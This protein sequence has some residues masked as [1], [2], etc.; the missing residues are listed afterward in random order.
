MNMKGPDFLKK[1]FNLHAAPEV[2][3]A[4]KRTAARTGEKVPQKAVEQ[5]QNYLD[6]F[7]EL[8]E[9]KDDDKKKLGMRALK[10]V[11]HDA[12]VIKPENIP[13]SHFRLLQQIQREQ[14]H[15]TVEVTAEMRKDAERIIKADQRASLDRWVDYLASEQARYPD[16]CKYWAFRSVVAMSLYDKEKKQF[17]NRSKHTTAPFPDLNREALAYVVDVVGKR[18]SGES[19]ENPV[20]PTDDYYDSGKLVSDEEFQHILSTE[21][22]AKYYAFA[23]EHVIADSTELLKTIEGQWRFFKQGSDPLELAKTLQGHGTGWCVA[24]ESTAEDYLSDGD[25]HVYYS[26]NPHNVPTIPRLSI[27]MREGDID[28]VRGVAHEQEIDPYIGPVLDEKLDEFGSKAD[29]WKEKAADMKWLTIIERKVNESEALTKDD[30]RFLY[31]I[32]KNIEGFGNDRDPRIGEIIEKRDKFADARV[33]LGEKDDN[34]FML[35]ILDADHSQVCKFLGIHI[36]EGEELDYDETGFDQKFEDF[37]ESHISEMKGLSQVV[38]D[39]LLELYMPRL[40]ADARDSFE[41]KDKFAIVSMMMEY[42]KEHGTENLEDLLPGFFNNV[43]P[44]EQVEFV[45]AQ[46]GK[47]DPDLLADLIWQVDHLP[48]GMAKRLIDAGEEKVL[49]N[50][51]KNFEVGLDSDVAIRLIEK[52]FGIEVSNNLQVFRGLN[53]EVYEELN[54]A[55]FFNDLEKNP[56]SFDL[57]G[58]R[59]KK[60]PF[61]QY[62]RENPFQ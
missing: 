31:E 35:K 37:L 47:A 30:I 19:V 58:G 29:E 3:K 33:A 24:G 1:R 23:I 15:G 5:I 38:A 27:F 17:G 11:L 41:F 42:D 48:L 25:F 21:N 55:G 62:V 12:Y 44:Q 22:F 13:E 57:S 2:E 53:D 34:E 18:T 40:V 56:Q 9:R 28:E 10:K 26:N 51:L 36:P 6:R 54:A 14:G 45:E 7:K 8:V 50:G 39:K 60:N 4:A 59:L 20:K 32:E 49:A 16:W 52:G 61:G 46:I 43:S